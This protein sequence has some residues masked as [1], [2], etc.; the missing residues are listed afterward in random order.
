M[1]ILNVFDEDTTH[2]A[3]HQKPRFF[4]LRWIIGCLLVL[5]L[6][7]ESLESAGSTDTLPPF[8]L[9]DKV[10]HFV[11]YLAIAAWF[12]CIVEP[13]HYWLVAVFMF[14]LGAW[15]ELA[16]WLMGLGRFAEWG[17][18]LADTLGIGAVLV[19]AYAGLGSWMARIEQR[20][21]L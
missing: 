3:A 12:I 16:Q 18:L 6:M 21:H 15:L 8:L 20:F 5:F 7:Y 9:G 11:S 19:L 14:V 1:K 13:R 10:L 2:T 17:D 4:S